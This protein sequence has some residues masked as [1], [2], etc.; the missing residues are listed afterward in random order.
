MKRLLGGMIG[1]AGDL[2]DMLNKL[3]QGHNMKGEG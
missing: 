2:D 1:I 3:N